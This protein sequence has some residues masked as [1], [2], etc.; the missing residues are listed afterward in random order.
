VKLVRTSLALTALAVAAAHAQPTFR[1]A[2]DLVTVPITVTSKDQSGRVGG[3]TVADFRLYEDGVLQELALI[4]HEP[5]ALSLCILLDSSPS[6]APRQTLATRAIDTLLRELQPDDEVSL[7]MFS[8]R[9]RV[10]VPWTRASGIRSYS[11]YSWRLSLGTALIDAMREALSSMEKAT[12]PKP[13]ILIVSDGADNTS[14]TPISKLVATRRQS[15]TMVYGVHTSGRPSRTATPLNRAFAV[16][17]LPELVG[18]SGGTVYRV[19]DPDAAENAA[20]AFLEELRSQYTL[21]YE[22]KK[23]Y[24]GKYRQLK[25][26]AAN[27]ALI[28]RHREGYLAQPR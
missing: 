24:D 2:V 3:L 7:L 27:P 1:S 5:R 8:S 28:V 22:P 4:T 23:A 11:W 25:I 16:D 9:V 19:V 13:V 17:F 20:L 14:G 15:E 18:D 10:A 21:G 6:M 26:E 12:N